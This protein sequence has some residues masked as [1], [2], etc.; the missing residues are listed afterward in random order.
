MRNQNYARQR[1]LELQE[2]RAAEE[3]NELMELRSMGIKA[4]YDARRTGQM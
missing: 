1:D 4:M 2:Q 3:A